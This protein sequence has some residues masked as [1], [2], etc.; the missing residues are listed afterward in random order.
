ML[1]VTI[2]LSGTLNMIW[3]DSKRRQSA[4]CVT[5]LSTSILLRTLRDAPRIGHRSW[6]V[7]KIAPTYIL[8][9]GRHAT[10][11]EDVDPAIL[12]P[13]R[14]WRILFRL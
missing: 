14:M 2:F 13:A 5:I 12:I 1:V 8:N 3:R 10:F 4:D 6:H 7:P 11:P 9:C